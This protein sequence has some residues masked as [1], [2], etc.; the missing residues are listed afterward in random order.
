MGETGDELQNRNKWNDWQ[1]LIRQ[2]R[3]AFI[4]CCTLKLNAKFTCW[5]I[6]TEWW[7]PQAMGR[8]KQRNTLHKEKRLNKN[9]NWKVTISQ[10]RKS[11]TEAEN[12]YVVK[13]SWL[14]LHKT[15]DIWKESGLF[16]YLCKIYTQIHMYICTH[17]HYCTYVY[18][19]INTTALWQ[20]SASDS[21]YK[22]E[23]CSCA[24]LHFCLWL[25]RSNGRTIQNN[26]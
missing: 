19:I 23:C 14:T 17:R 22:E 26:S 16:V 13:T 24:K 25:L 4:A 12:E 1:I 2:K 7:R 11:S 8:R 6:Q 21:G 20:A 18:A 3:K 9:S 5:S 15:L 10:M